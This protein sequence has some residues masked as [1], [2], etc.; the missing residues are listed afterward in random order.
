M[1]CIKGKQTKHTKK[2]AIRSS[3]FLEIIH[4]NICGPFNAPSFIKEK[5][6]ITFVDD[7]SHYTYIYLLHEKSQAVESL[8]VYITVVE[9]QLERNVKIIRSDK[10]GKY[11]GKYDE[12]G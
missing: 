10:G 5:Y 3:E 2:S 9:R 11:Y 8:A 12:S 4:S 7:F 1:D 6:F